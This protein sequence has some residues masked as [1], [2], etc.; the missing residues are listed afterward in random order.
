MLD[1]AVCA[2]MGAQ[3]EFDPCPKGD[4]TR[5]KDD[6]G[7]RG[8]DTIKCPKRNYT[9]KGDKTPG[10]KIL[11]LMHSGKLDQHHPVLQ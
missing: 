7:P 3:K 11:R 2:A 6:P 1:F 5:K 8:D 4:D 10:D 9:L